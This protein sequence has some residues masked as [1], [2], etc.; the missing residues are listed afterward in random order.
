MALWKHF[1]A[2]RCPLFTG[3]ARETKFAIKSLPAPHDF[4]FHDDD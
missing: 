1:F 2:I 4:Y 3:L